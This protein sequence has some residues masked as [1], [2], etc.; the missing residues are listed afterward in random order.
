MTFILFNPARGCFVILVNVIFEG[1]ER[2][3]YTSLNVVS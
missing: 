3:L 2:Y 1:E